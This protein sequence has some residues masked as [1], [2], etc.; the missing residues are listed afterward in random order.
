[1]KYSKEKK[2]EKEKVSLWQKFKDY[3]STTKL[4]YY[5]HKTISP[6]NTYLTALIIFS[7]FIL[8]SYF[9]Y[10]MFTVYEERQRVLSMQAGSLSSNVS[11]EDFNEGTTDV[12]VSANSTKIIDIAI[13]NNSITK[14]KIDLNCIK[15]DD[16]SVSY[17]NG[18]NETLPNNEGDF[19]LESGESKKV[20]VALIN[21]SAEERNVSFS[22]D[23]GLSSATLNGTNYV[24]A[25]SIDN[26]YG[27]TT[28][29]YMLRNST[30]FVKEIKDNY[31]SAS[32]SNVEVSGTYHG[33]YVSGMYGETNYTCPT[34]MEVSIEKMND[35]LYYCRLI[36]GECPNKAFKYSY[37]NTNICINYKVNLENEFELS[38][39]TDEN[40]DIV[41]Y[42]RGGLDKKNIHSYIKIG[43]LR[44]NVVRI[45]EDGS[46][47]L[48]L[49]DIDKNFTSSIGDNVT[50]KNSLIKNKLDEWYTSHLGGVDSLLVNSNYCNDYSVDKESEAYKLFYKDN[51]DVYGFSNRLINISKLKADNVKPTLKCDNEYRFNSKIGL[52][53][54]DEV[55]LAGNS[56]DTFLDKGK[57]K[58]SLSMNY[59]M[60][61]KLEDDVNTWL[62]SPAFGNTYYYLNSGLGTYVGNSGVTDTSV[63]RPVITLK[64][65]VKY[66]TGTGTLDD[67]YIIK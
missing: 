18:F 58:E 4:N 27:S 42:F 28:I 25:N 63:I 7:L 66:T 30:P 22:T 6:K 41:Y 31:S 5:L 13:N 44:W 51:Y 36:E 20:T 64:A 1:M 19:I 39:T 10:A 14:A 61:E 54:A 33:I 50:Y 21:T 2:I 15:T 43:D 29:A 47:R 67:P 59:L 9:S 56:T 52:L 16:V 53:T 3:L 35:S 32:I 46:L 62:M 26:P 49:A 45:N 17:L 55:F 34:N 37:N 65:G 8:I 11:S 57:N 23:I 60:P 48:V 24:V 38:S 12:P 40:N